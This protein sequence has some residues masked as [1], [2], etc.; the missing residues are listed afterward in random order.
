MILL[1]QQ[2]KLLGMYQRDL[3]EAHKYR[4]SYIYLAV[5]IVRLVVTPAIIV[6]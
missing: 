3:M 1:Q 2:E 6:Y 5:F 4:S